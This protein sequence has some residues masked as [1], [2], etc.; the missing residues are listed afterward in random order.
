MSTLQLTAAGDLD[1]TAGLTLLS[2]LVAETAQR[3]QNKFRMFQG[4]WELEPRAG[5]PMF[6]KVLV[7][8][9]NISELNRLYRSVLLADTA[10][11]SIDSLT[12]DFDRSLRAL[13]ISFEATL[14]DGSSLEFTDFILAEN[15]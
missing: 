14:N 15:L 3:L 7:K 6:E 11:D 8:N 4:E 1:T 2:D 12:L 9:P 13:S 5:M 10:V